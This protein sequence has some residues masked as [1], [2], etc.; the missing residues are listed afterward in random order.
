MRIAIIDGMNQDI[1]LKILYPNADYYVKN[2]EFDKSHSFNKYHIK[3]I[4]DWSNINDNN[5][6]CLF[7]IIALYDTI[8]NT[9]FYK[10]NI[11][12]ILDNI[13]EIINKNNFKII[14]F[15]DN[16]DY[17]YDPNTIV[18]NS[19]INFFFKRNF[20]LNL[21]Y[22]DNVIPFPFIM[23]G[24][25]SIIE[26][27]DE[28]VLYSDYFKKKQN[29]IFFS[30]S[31]FIHDDP[32]YKVYKNRNIIYNKIKSY[33]YNPG[34]LNFNQYIN[35]LRNSKFGL[36]LS[37]VGD[38]NKRTFEIL[39]S[40]SLLISQKNN[41]KWT[42]DDNFSSDTIFEN[43]KD[44]YEKINLL[45]ND[46]ELYLNCL[47]NQYNIVIKYFNNHNIKKYIENFIK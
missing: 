1:G 17:D 34:M 38:P 12:I 29:R 19:K 47:K 44:F 15:F 11:K 20:N 5:Y 26:K 36:D 4:F 33:I 46:D 6:D 39:M 37:G 16:Y 28:L 21:S 14:A 40:G 3:P 31:L 45:M 7:V 42:F 13:L 10:E 23:F 30:G 32:Q 22:C 9:K 41:L 27:F 25:Y 43:E 24:N 2:L 18:N 35:E 8:C